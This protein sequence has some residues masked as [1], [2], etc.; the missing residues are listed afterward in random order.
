METLTLKCPIRGI[1]KTGA[2]SKDG[3]KPSEEYYRVEAIKHLLKLGYPK[4]HVKVEAV[5]KRF[6]NGGKNSF[7]A[8][9]AVLDVPVDSIAQGDVDLL[10]NHAVL[11]CEVKR[12]NNKNDYVKSTQVRPLLDFAKL[13][14][15]IALYWDN[16]DQRV[17]WTELHGSVRQIKEGPL[18]LLPAYGSQIHIKPLFYE[19]LQPNDDLKGLFTRIEDIL[20]AAS[21]DPEQRFA[22]LMQLLLAKLFDEH[23]HKNA[24]QIPLEIQDYQSLGNSSSLALTNFNSLL[25]N[26]ASYYS[27]HLPRS[28][29]KT[30]PKKV[31][32]DT[33]FEIVKLLAPIQL[34]ASKRHVVQEFY[35]KFAKGLYKWDL[36]QFFTPPTVTDFIIDV[37]NPRFGEHIKDPA[38]GSADFLTA[39]FHKGRKY[40]DN[41]ASNI[42]GSDNSEN[43]VQVAVLNMLLNGDGKSNIHE[44]DS[45]ESVD[46]DRN[47]YDIMVCNPPFGVR[48]LEKRPS[49]LRQFQLGYE[50]DWDPSKKTFIQS[51]KLLESQEAGLL[52]AEVCVAQAKDDKGRIGIILPNGY[53][54][55]RSKKYRFFREWL[56]KNTRV[57]AICSFPR[58]TFKTSGADVSASI[59]YLE[60]RKEPIK[61][62]SECDEYHIAIEMIENVGW[63]L[64]DKKAAPRFQR[65][66]EDG[67]YIVDEQGEKVLDADFTSALSNIRAS[68]AAQ[69]FPW[70]ADNIQSTG[71]SSGWSVSI[72]EILSDDDLTLDPKRY[73]RKTIELRQKIASQPHIRL[74][75]LV[76][77]IPEKRAASG[78]LLKKQSEK[79]YNYIELQDIGFGDFKTNSVRGW[80]LPDR[81]KHFAEPEDIFVASIWGSVTKWCLIPN[82]GSDLVVTNGCHRLRMKQG[83]SSLIVD[84]VAFLCT[85]AYAV[86]MRAMARGSD[87][88]AEITVDDAKQV[89]IP[90]LTEHER[91]QLSPYVHSLL[92]GTPDLRSKIALML[93]QNALGYP[94]PPKRPSHVALV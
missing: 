81:A 22:V 19:D 27:K 91:A 49:V 87:G 92:S 70:L 66:A 79:V 93:N 80:E 31:S 85:E 23:K 3:L 13:Q 68:A 47:T 90:K 1:L 73:C 72:N 7:R 21:V 29:N 14:G 75:D 32:G 44:R 67:S 82:T 62:L 26:A 74:G 59:V 6:G 4:S 35:M 52:F 69:D 45:L 9:L 63:N 60:K 46:E 43:A 51:K 71:K 25:G 18:A 10:L 54:A 61:T 34:I 11:L 50:H 40:D 77:F 78:K 20:H 33:L 38:C 86:Q 64:G 24:K 76:D 65:N 36:A 17:F 48:I 53:L 94:Q 16:V 28:V 37:I 55:N 39:A 42:W 89:L 84:L 56:L 41:Y 12:D 5:I 57:V 58:F 30:L 83:Q 88:L 2:K 8:D 15:C